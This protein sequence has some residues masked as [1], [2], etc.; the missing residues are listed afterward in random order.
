MKKII[1]LT[2]MIV[3]FICQSCATLF[4]SGKAMVSIN[5]KTKATTVLVNGLEKGTTPL[6]IKLKA[7]DIISFEKEGYESK[8]VVV[9]SKFNTIAILNLFSIFGWAIDAITNSLKIPDTKI[10]NVTLKEEN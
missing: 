8:Q 3:P 5:S 10:Y 6:S 9:D 1:L 7:D 2:I 4:T